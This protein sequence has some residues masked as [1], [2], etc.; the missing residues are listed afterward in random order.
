MSTALADKPEP[1]PLSVDIAPRKATSSRWRKVYVV[2]TLLVFAALAG[3][4][5][6]KASGSAEWKLVKDED[7]V[8]VYSLKVPGDKLIKTKTVMEGDY[9]LSQVAAPHIIDHNLET[10][11]KWIPNCIA[12]TP[13]KDFDPVTRYSVDMW[14]LDF[15]TPFSDREL[16]ISTIASQD[17]ASKAVA[18]DIVVLPNVL[19]HNEGV[20]RMHNRWKFTPRQNGKVEVEL[21][22]DTNLGG[23]FP[24]FLMNMVIVDESH[25]FFRT[26]LRKVL[27]EQKY[28][29]AK[30][31]FIDDIS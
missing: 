9:T 3:D 31:E 7:G 8:K 15:P 12:V 20:V 22:Q 2:F 13:I 4:A 25:T 18:L 1:A 23:S 27:T 5:M 16:L 24:Y 28:V 14:R 29:N 10:C 19:P 30:F 21:I 6:W 17:P 26:E 11:K